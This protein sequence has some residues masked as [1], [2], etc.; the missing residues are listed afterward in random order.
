VAVSVEMFFLVNLGM[1]FLTV[2]VIA[3]YRG[4]VK[5]K[6]LLGASAAGAVY[7]V[8]M[9]LPAFAA[10]K[11]PVC[12]AALTVLMAAFALRPEN[13]RDLFR[14]A[15]LLVASSALLGGAQ[16]A[17]R[18][19]MGGR[20]MTAILLGAVLGAAFLFMLFREKINRVEKW[21]VQVIARKRGQ[22]V[23]F[24]ALIDT[25]NRLHEPISGLPVLIVEQKQI[26][27]LLPEGFCNEAIC[28]GFRRIAFGGMGGNGFLQAF[29]PDELLV[30]Y[31]DGWM[32]APAI[33]IGVYPG[34]MPGDVRALAPAL[35]G[36]VGAG[37][38]AERM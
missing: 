35:L 3:R 4:R 12:R 16:L 34:C 26:E 36:T 17:A 5:G 13:I 8:L 7:A 31:S 23:H 21:E 37:G 19:M 25:G 24:T 9:H 11:A 33:W 38:M 18:E 6:F 27:R 22:Q 14:S 32:R 29:R 15:A 20:A 1:N 30:N 28:P 2:A 10:L